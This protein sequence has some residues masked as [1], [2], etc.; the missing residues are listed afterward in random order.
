MV[1]RSDAGTSGDLLAGL[2]LTAVHLAVVIGFVRLF[3]D[4]SFLLPLLAV[5]IVTHL[6][7]V[8]GR[9][10][11]LHPS[12]TIPL[13]LLA[14]ALTISWTVFPETTMRGI[15]TSETVDAVVES[16]R[17]ARTAFD[18]VVA[19]TE[20]L[21]GFIV[22]LAV[23][24]GFSVWFA[25]WAAFHLGGFAEAITPATILFLFSTLL[26][27]GDHRVPI[28]VLFA[29][30]VLAFALLRRDGSNR[31]RTHAEGRLERRG[32][33]GSGALLGLAALVI[34]ALV[35]PLLPG[36]D[37]P[38]MLRWR[39]QQTPPARRST[40]SPMVSLR[41]RL[42]DQSDV[43]LFRVR[44]DQPAYWRLTA[45]DEF[46]GTIWR[47]DSSFTGAGGNLP[48]RDPG[49]G[50]LVE[51]DYEIGELDDLWVPAA[52]RAE[53]VSSGDGS[54]RWDPRS[55]TLIVDRDLD[56][57][58]GL[59]Y[60]VS[61]RLPTPT[62]DQLR[63]ADRPDP[64]DLAGFTRLPED[65]PAEVDDLARSLTAGADGRYEQ[66]LALQG[67]FRREFRYSTE[68]PEGHDEDAIL[69]F[70]DR[71][72]G[73]CEQFAGTFAA[74]ARS[75]GVPARVGVGF[76]PGD[77]VPGEPGWYQV[78]GRHAHAWPEV[79]F[80]GI[81]WVPF[82]P[83]PGRGLGATEPYTGV[84]AQQDA[85]TGTP[86]EQPATTTT[87][88]ASDDPG[89]TADDPATG[90]ETPTPES[91]SEPVTDPGGRSL[92]P[93]LLV[94]L[95]LITI[96]VGALVVLRRRQITA[97]NRPSSALTSWDRVSDE[98]ERTT[99]LD[100]RPPETLPEYVGRVATTGID[101]RTI[102]DLDRLAALAD[103][104]AWSPGGLGPDAGDEAD[105]IADRL[106]EELRASR[107]GG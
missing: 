35:A 12:V 102:H 23:A 27:S 100:R 31:D 18:Q 61:S 9:R 65:F 50:V 80:E 96:L 62:P 5:V 101:P 64:P 1:R 34:G 16:V 40:V 44:A 28:A 66:M 81:G 37:E 75:L 25:D 74:M 63:G 98:L 48:G 99:G 47:I 21:D 72:V 17:I 33:I 91:P 88:P 3:D 2:S 54:L 19:P 73:Y 39:R 87:Q 67:F 70:L 68:I 89:D 83:T 77:E 22:L 94:G 53:S 15:P 24:L 10:A 14:G 76:T 104:A 20:P 29:G 26:G 86:T 84:P 13:A 49:T 45:L 95:T 41:P 103:R 32:R 43:E 93:A 90:E 92:L 51:Q 85:G 97:R 52:L 56:S 55:S 11:R 106:I 71:R 79:H 69:A 4:R 36:A 7:T 82:E 107:T 105:R 8:L 59:R 6:G 38:G 58:S 30:T 57:V 78:R 46:D 42:V 60:S